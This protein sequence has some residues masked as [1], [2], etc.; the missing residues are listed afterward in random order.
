MEA[1]GATSSN[2]VMSITKQFV[3]Y[4][5]VPNKRGAPNK[6][7]GVAKFQKSNKSG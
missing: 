1:E 4:S 3:D 2:I 7:G 6:S 5:R